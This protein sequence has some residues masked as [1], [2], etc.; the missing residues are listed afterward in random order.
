MATAK[1]AQK[2]EQKQPSQ[3]ASAT[4]DKVTV[5]SKFIR[6]SPSKLRRVAN[7]VRGKSAEDANSLL[8]ALPHRG[9]EILTK[10]LKSGV[11]NAV[12]NL[13]LDHKDLVVSEILVSE[14]PRFKRF[15][16]RARGRVNQIIKQTSHVYIAL[17]PGGEN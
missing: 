7:V 11:S 15:K 16:A 8:R 17:T 14:G 6:I 9:A 13:K 10:V 12:N 2:A 5:K 1:K 3:L 4:N